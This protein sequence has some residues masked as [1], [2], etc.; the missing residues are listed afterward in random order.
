MASHSN[1]G[2]ILYHF[3]YKATYWS[4]ITICSYPPALGCHHPN[5][6]TIF[7]VEKLERCGYLTVRKVRDTFSRFDTIPPCD[8]QTDGQ[9][10]ILRQHSLRYA[11]HRVIITAMKDRL[12][13][14]QCRAPCMAHAG[15]R[16]PHPTPPSPSPPFPSVPSTPFPP[17]PSP[18]SPYLPLPSLP[19]EAGPLS[20]ARGSGAE[21]QPKLNLVERKR[22]SRESH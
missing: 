14:C 2:A 18:P 20:P 10:D 5:I 11:R 9:T 8:R 17:L 3:R 15:L 12:V 19:L 6:T 4:T 13:F 22:R 16:A 21:L 7:G 1:Y